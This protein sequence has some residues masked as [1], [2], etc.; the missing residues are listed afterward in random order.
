YEEMEPLVLA[1]DR[2]PVAVWRVTGESTKAGRF[3]ALRRTPMMALGGRKQEMEGLRRCWANTIDGAGQVVILTGEPGIGKSRLLTEFEDETNVESYDSLRY[4]G[5]PHQTDAA[6]YAVIGELQRAAGFN[7]TDNP[8]ERLAKLTALLE[9][10]AKSTTE[11][12]T[13]IADLL[14]L[15]VEIGQALQQLTPQERKKRTLATLLARI[16]NLA[17]RRP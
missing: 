16:G 4:F 17:A 7:R 2:A 8:S 6:L 12:V 9:G 15:P 13:L 11:E 5:S 10:S 1:D 3:E 14:A